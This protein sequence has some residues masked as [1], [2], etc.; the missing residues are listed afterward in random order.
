MAALSPDLKTR[1]RVA[2]ALVA[3]L[4][5][6]AV[7]GADRPR[8]V[9]QEVSLDAASSEVDYRSNTIVFRDIVIAQ[10]GIRV[11]AEQARATGL[12]FEKSTW[13]FLGKVRITV[14]GGAMKSNEATVNFLASRIT[15]ATILGNPAEFEQPRAGTA[16]MARGRAGSIAYDV[17]GGIIPLSRSAWLSD[18]RSEISGEELVYNVREQRVQAQAPAGR[19]DRVRITIRPRATRP[20]SP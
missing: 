8:P 4:A 19:S 12:D 16:E 1:S 3:V 13:R 18:G 9:N 5:A 6:A 17:P 15:R 14:D 7:M 20:P 11:T 10:G 2:A